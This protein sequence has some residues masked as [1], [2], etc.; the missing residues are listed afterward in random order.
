MRGQQVAFGALDDELHGR[1]VQVELERRR[2]RAQPLRQLRELHRPD[3]QPRAGGIE[4]LDPG[5]VVLLAL[6]LAGEHQVDIV[7]D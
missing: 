1:V 4:R 7:R 3:G 6:E 2:A 5:R